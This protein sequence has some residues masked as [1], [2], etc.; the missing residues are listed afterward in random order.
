MTDKEKI[1]KK[2]K[3]KVAEP[4]EMV[5]EAKPKTI[6]VKPEVPKVK[7][8][9]KDSKGCKL[10]RKGILGRRGRS[11]KTRSIPVSVLASVTGTDSITSAALRV[12]YGWRDRTR[13]TREEYLRLRDEW[14][15]KPACEVKS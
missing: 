14:L 15:N 6:E 4:K 5:V 7:P 3:T 9:S 1:E 12:A 13:L 11:S 2:D 8:I 10:V